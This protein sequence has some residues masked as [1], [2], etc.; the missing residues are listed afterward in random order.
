[1]SHSIIVALGTNVDTG[2]LYRARGVLSEM[3]ADVQF[4]GIIPTDPIGER[5]A[6]RPFYNF[7][8]KASC[9]DTADSIQDRLKELERACGDSREQRCQ[10]RVVLDADLLAF[11]GTKYH[12][13]DWE[14]PYIKTL[15]E[16]LGEGTGVQYTR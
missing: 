9:P 3:F 15:L 1:M 2:V 12:E 13:A 11:D 7:V 5:F 4:T 14:R 10:G 6:G 8:A 16:A